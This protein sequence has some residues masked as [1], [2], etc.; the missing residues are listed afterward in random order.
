[1]MPVSTTANSGNEIRRHLIRIDA[2]IAF[3]DEPDLK[4]A[5]EL[6]W[7]DLAFDR[8]RPLAFVCLPGGNI[9]RGYFDLGSE[10]SPSFSFAR[11]MAKR[12]A[13][14]I[15]VDHLGVG[16]SSRPKDGFLLTPD[17]I[18]A[19]NAHAIGHA[20]AMLKSGA[21]N[22]ELP[23][24]PTL[25]TIGVGHSMGAML[26]AMQQASAPMHRAI[27]LLGFSAAGLPEY[28]PKSAHDL[29]GAP[30]EI[31]E[32][33]VELA[34]EMFE[35]PYVQ[36]RS[37]GGGASMFYSSKADAEGI[38]LLREARDTLL[39]TPGLQ[40]LIP[41]SIGPQLQTIDVPVFLGLGDHD[42]AGPPHAVPPSLPAS[43]DVTLIVLPE[44]GHCHFIFP[45]RAVLFQRLADWVATVRRE[46]STTGT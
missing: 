20:V 22:S 44:T 4:V 36:I 17:V 15:A 19:A 23:A 38:E 12:G 2:G 29:I 34:R 40:C 30:S 7:H 25:A 45:S 13:L 39:A 11:Q 14:V 31:P 1:M 43:R 46:F 33:I 16:A 9:N 5:V 10:S 26:T 18:V 35:T 37:S 6:I 42:M 21:I 24:L 8:E 28:L 32:R 3:P 27:V 41:G